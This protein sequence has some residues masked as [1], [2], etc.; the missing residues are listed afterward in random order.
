MTRQIQQ[1]EMKL[2]CEH[3]NKIDK[4]RIFQSV[5]KFDISR[6]GNNISVTKQRLLFK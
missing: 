2:Q 1:F 3:A 4:N 6:V 5:F